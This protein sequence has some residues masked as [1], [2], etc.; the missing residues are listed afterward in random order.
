MPSDVA[1]TPSVRIQIRARGPSGQKILDLPSFA[2]VSD[3]K[4]AIR[5]KFELEAFQIRIGHPSTIL[6]LPADETA[7]ADLPMRIVRETLTVAA[8]PVEVPAAAASANGGRYGDE[9]VVRRSASPGAQRQPQPAGTPPPPRSVVPGTGDSAHWTPG[10]FSQHPSPPHR[11]QSPPSVVAGS[12]TSPTRRATRRDHPPGYREAQDL[13]EVELP[14]R[15]A[16]LGRWLPRYLPTYHYIEPLW[17]PVTYSFPMSYSHS[18][19]GPQHEHILPCANGGGHFHAVP[20][21]QFHGMP[22]HGGW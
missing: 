7:L 14:D 15:N 10:F 17:Q 6:E 22:G 13:P 21:N 4:A 16:L 3:L 1:A 8:A 19:L 5:S 12:T 9:G 20:C 11:P 18:L 2:R